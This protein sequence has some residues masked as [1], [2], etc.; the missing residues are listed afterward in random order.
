MAQDP[1]VKKN[2]SSSL[3]EAKADEL[4]SSYVFSFKK[5]F[6]V[7][8]YNRTTTALGYIKGLLKMEKGQGNMERMEEELPEADHRAY[9]H[10]LTHSDW[11]AGAVM[12]E[13][14]VQADQVMQ[15]EKA[16]SGLVTGLIIDES[17]HLKKGKASVGVSRQYAGVVGK[18][19]NCQVGVYASLV[20]GERAAL[21][22]ESLHLPK[23]WAEDTARCREAGVPEGDCGHRTK[24]EQALGLVDRMDGL[25]IRFGWVGGDGLYGHTARLR[26]GLDRRKKHFLLD[27]HKD[28]KVFL[29]PPV[30]ALPKPKGRGRKPTKTRPSVPAFRLDAYFESIRNEPS[31]WSEEHI[32]NGQKG[33]IKLKVHK[34]TVWSEESEGEATERLLVITQGEKVKYSLSNFGPEDHTHQQ[35]GWMQAQRYWVERTFDDAKN[36]LCMSDYQVRK[37]NGWHRHH[38]LVFMAALFLLKERIRMEGENPLMSM[39]DARELIV[40]SLFGTPEQ[41]KVKTDQMHSR[42]R[43]RQKDIDRFYKT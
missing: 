36:E 23:A 17:A 6:Q 18:V 15:A 32:R 34:A 1:S 2:L 37:W 12:D 24:P 14:A 13:V 20:N 11:D 31:K 27:V 28:E 21:V 4:L 35:L 7:Y 25:G 41:V 19:E 42:H 22:G 29:Q 43:K 3:G 10:F 39:R 33:P 26:K 5:L 16:K 40:V 8:R 38:A 9:Q 30:F